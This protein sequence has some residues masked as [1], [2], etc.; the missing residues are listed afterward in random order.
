MHGKMHIF[1]NLFSELNQKD[2]FAASWCML[3]YK[4]MKCFVVLKHFTTA[5]EIGKLINIITIQITI[6]K[7]FEKCNIF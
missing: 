1:V 7:I 5:L 2:L 4:L 6:F 3:F